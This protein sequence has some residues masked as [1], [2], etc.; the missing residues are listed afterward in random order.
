MRSR[1][2]LVLILLC[3]LSDI[4]CRRPQDRLKPV[5][6]SSQKSLVLMNARITDC[7]SGV[8]TTPRDMYIESGY[9]VKIE[10]PSESH[11]PFRVIDCAGKFAVAGLFDCHTHL[12][13]LA[14]QNGENTREKLAGFVKRG[15]T[16]V[17]DVGGPIDV[18]G[19]MHERIATGELQGPELFY[20]GPMLER[21]PLTYAGMNET[22]SGF[23]VAVNS[24]DDVDRILPDLARQGACMV[25]VFNK[26]DQDVFKHLIAV[27]Q[28]NS[29]RVV[30]DPGMPLFHWVSMDKAIEMGVS[31]IEHAKSPWPAVLT[32]DLK[33]EHDRLLDS[34]ENEML[35][36]MFMMR[37]AGLGTESVSMDKLHRLADLM[38]EK[39]AYLCPTLCVLASME[40]LAIAQVKQQQ[41]IEE[42]P[43]FMMQ[44]IRKN[45]A[46]M[47][48]VSR[49]F[50]REFA[51][52]GVRM[53][54]GQDGVAPAG[55]FAE[56]RWMKE[57]GVSDL[58]ILRGATIYPARW[59]GVEDRLGAIAPGY[60]ANILIVNENPL[61]DVANLEDAF[62]VVHK[63]QV[64]GRE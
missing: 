52:H 60:E 36:M 40:E 45:I 31:S 21:G 43:E 51:A 17:R 8:T 38:I 28:R 5:T 32:D 1:M 42:I 11:S 26:I 50:V 63:G 23:T 12:A 9:V 56:M 34:E 59:L 22:L 62:L 35:R 44:A 61:E 27:A 41:H 16:Q 13:H 47:E 25:K 3:I 37:V 57:C 15:I 2:L 39:D 24:T 20:A 33:E 10:K 7:V 55:V 49:L 14:T 48:A 4:T 64:A 6:A 19:L 46:G 29:L 53:M 18:L 30:F 54:V 58:E